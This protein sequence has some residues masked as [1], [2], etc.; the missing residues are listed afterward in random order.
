MLQ[1]VTIEITAEAPPTPSTVPPHATQHEEGGSDEL[2]I[3]GL[4]G[5]TADLQVPRPH[6]AGH[7]AGGPDQ[8]NVG[9][10]LGELGTDQP[11][12]VHGNSRH[13]PAF[14]TAA[15]LAAHQTATTAHA[16]AT[17][18]ANRATTGPLTGLIPDAQLA[19]QSEAALQGQDP[20]RKAL[21]LAAND[22]PPTGRRF[23]WPWPADHA[24]SHAPGGRDPTL[25]AYPPTTGTYVLLLNNVSKTL[26]WQPWLP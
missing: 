14:A 20:T 4:R 18:L 6:A 1:P 11:A 16:S 25:P 12:K 23:G 9:G 22:T 2:S 3:D 10:L 24:A 19:D 7:Q 15:S 8:I 21:L 26:Y 17:N 13:D 5:L